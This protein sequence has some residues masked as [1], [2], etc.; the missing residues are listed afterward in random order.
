MLPS[1]T[2]SE[3]ASK[4]EVSR[5]DRRLG[6]PRADQARYLAFRGEAVEPL[7]RKGSSRLAVIDLSG[8]ECQARQS[9]YWQADPG[10]TIFFY[11]LRG[12]MVQRRP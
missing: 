8:G 2:S 12:T 11:M 6:G 10:A 7:S 9:A 5:P 1:T 4:H 3:G